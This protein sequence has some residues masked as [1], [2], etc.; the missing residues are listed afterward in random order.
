MLISTF[1]ENWEHL[2]YVEVEMLFIC[3][4]QAWYGRFVASFIVKKKGETYFFHQYHKNESDV[5]V[6]RLS[7]KIEELAEEEQILG[8]VRVFKQMC[9][10]L[11]VVQIYYIAHWPIVINLN[12]L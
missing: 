1:C 3:Q 10:Y 4:G 6:H 2:L 12:I 9:K 5:S 7:Y 11:A 8:Y